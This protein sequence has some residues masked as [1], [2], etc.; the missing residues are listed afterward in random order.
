M[1]TPHQSTSQDRRCPGNSPV[2]IANDGPVG[3]TYQ[4]GSCHAR[5]VICPKC[6]RAQIYCSKSCSQKVRRSRL[7]ADIKAAEITSLSGIAR[8]LNERS[9]ST[10]RGGKWQATQVRNLLARLHLGAILG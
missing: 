10:S 4:C 6:D 1:Q 7:I 9:I 2:C 8:A 5:V 3:R